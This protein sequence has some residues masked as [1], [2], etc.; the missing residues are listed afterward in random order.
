MKK[1]MMIMCVMVMLFTTIPVHAASFTD[2]S[3]SHWAYNNIM[4][5]SQS[6]VVNGYEDG[7][8][9]PENMVTYGEFMKLVICTYVPNNGYKT[10]SANNHWASG[11]VIGAELRGFLPVGLVSFDKLDKPIDRIN[12]AKLLALIDA[13]VTSEEYKK[14]KE[15]D[16]VDI[17]GLPNEYVQ[18]IDRL[19]NRGYIKGNPDKTFKPADN[20]SRAEMVTIL[21]RVMGGD[22]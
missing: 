5:L 9:R 15:L 13:R 7:T 22:A 19:V 18:Y 21:L 10:L 3:T 16:F 6:G 12:M 8:F 17:G 4:S 14:I 2:L 20:L 11:Y 1:L